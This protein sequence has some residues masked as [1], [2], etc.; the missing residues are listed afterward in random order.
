MGKCK[1][2]WMGWPKPCRYVIYAIL[3]VLGIAVLAFLFGLFIMLLWNW[4]MPEIFGLGEINYWQ[5]FGLFILG[6]LLFGSHFNNNNNNK[7]RT[8]VHKGCKTEN[9]KSNNEDIEIN[10]E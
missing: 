3:G 7:E 9:I 5:G 2:V 4:L 1:R 6:R 8:I 10:I